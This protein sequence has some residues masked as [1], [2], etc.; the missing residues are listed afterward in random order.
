MEILGTAILAILFVLCGCA[1]VAV[2]VEK[3][4]PWVV[5]LLLGKEYRQVRA[6]REAEAEAR[7]RAF[8]ERERKEREAEEQ[9]EAKALERAR[10][11]DSRQRAHVRRA[12]AEMGENRS[13]AV[14]GRKWR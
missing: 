3:G 5:G 4:L 9:E 14:K 1:L 8:E 6:R 12:V 13:E 2:I 11:M 7:G 10:E